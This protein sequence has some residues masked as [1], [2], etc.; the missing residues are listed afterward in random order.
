MF[1]EREA[2]GLGGEFLSQFDRSVRLIVTN[3][4]LGRQMTSK[5]R[6]L[7][8]RRFPFQIIY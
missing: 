3:P 8:L 6:R 5:L 1:Y 4:Q 2:A 7:L